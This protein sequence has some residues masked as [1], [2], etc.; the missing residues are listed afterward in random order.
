MTTS[1]SFDHWIGQ[2]APSSAGQDLVCR[3]TLR[4]PASMAESPT[5][6]I[7]VPTSSH[8]A[9]PRTSLHPF[10]LPHLTFALR[11]SPRGRTAARGST[12]PRRTATALLCACCSPAR[13]TP[14]WRTRCTPR[15]PPPL[16]PSGA[17]I[18]PTNGPYGTALTFDTSSRATHPPTS[19]PPASTPPKA[20]SLPSL[21]SS[22]SLMAFSSHYF[23]PLLHLPVSIKNFPNPLHPS[24]S[25]RPVLTTL[26]PT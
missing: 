20:L 26:T 4:P 15:R 16:P 7:A 8:P 1:Y 21:R 18:L 13:R 22:L 14:T 23:T 10:K 24:P 9:P 25:A 19:Q 2:T 11:I 6:R 17:R 12:W 3:P 5:P